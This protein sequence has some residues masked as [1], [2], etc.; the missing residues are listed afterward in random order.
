MAYGF[1]KYE[2]NHHRHPGEAAAL[3]PNRFERD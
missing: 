1:F 2:E 3:A